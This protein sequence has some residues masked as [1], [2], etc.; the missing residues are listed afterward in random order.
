MSETVKHFKVHLNTFKSF[1]KVKYTL[2]ANGNLDQRSR[3]KAVQHDLLEEDLVK[4]VALERA[5][6]LPV[7]SEVFQ[8]KARM[9]REIH[10]LTEDYFKARNGWLYRFVRRTG[11]RSQELHGEA[12]GVHS[13]YLQVE[14]LS[15][16]LMLSKY[17]PKHIYIQD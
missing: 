16:C 11:I 1:W 3:I 8:T 17:D 6:C 9:L 2:I 15:F 4:F 7:T 13:N 5:H 12:G 14:I 10:Q